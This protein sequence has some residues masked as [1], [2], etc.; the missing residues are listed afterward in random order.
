MNKKITIII[1][2]GTIL[3]TLSCMAIV[4]FLQQDDNNFHKSAPPPPP[5]RVGGEQGE[6]ASFNDDRNAFFDQ[7]HKAAPGTNWRKIDA[8]TRFQLMQERA[9]KYRTDDIAM[10]TLAD[11]AVIGEWKEMGSYNTAGRIWAT[12]VD[13][14]ND[15]VYA[16]SDGGNLWKG[17][18]D[19]T[20]WAVINDNFKLTGAHTL[21]KI[22]DRL[23]VGSGQ[24]GVQG[25]FY[26]EDEGVTWNST[27]GLENV[28]AWGYVMDAEILN[29]AEHTM[30]VLAYEWDYTNWW[31]IVSLYRSVDLG[32]SFTKV[33]SYDVPVYGGTNHFVLWSPPYGSATCYMVENNHVNVLD[34]TG[35]PVLV[36]ELPITEDGDY[37]LCGFE[38][39]SATDLYVA[40]RSYV[41]NFT[42]F[43]RSSDGGANWTATGMVEEGNFSKNSFSCSQSLQGYLYYGGVDSYR[44]FTGGDTWVRNNYWWEYYGDTEYNLHADIPF[45]RSFID[46]SGDEIVLVSTDGGLFRS[47]DHGL[48]WNNITNEGMRNAQ[49]YDVYTYRYVPDI[50]FAG[51]QDQGYQRSTYNVDDKYY[52][53]QLI[54]GDYGHF[55]SMNGGDDLWCVYPGFAMFVGDA[56]SGSVMTTWDF[57]G[58][59]HLWMAP[60][61]QDPWNSQVAWWGGGSDAGGAYLWR[62]QKSGIY[63]SAVKQD[64]NFSVAGGGSISAINYS[65]IDPNYWYLL[66][67]GGKFYYSEDAG[68]TWSLSSGFTGP[69]P[70]YFYGATIEPSKSQLG[71]VYI[72]GSGYDNAP[73][74]VS[75]DHGDNFTE[76][77]FGL[78][79]TLVY[80]LA[81]DNTDSLLFAATEVAPYV[82]VL[83]EG[84]W[85]NLAGND[86]PL[87]TYWSVDYVDEIKSVR[88]GTYGRGAWEFALRQDPTINVN[89]QSNALAM[90][91]YPNPA[92]ERL[93]IMIPMNL[94]Q[95]TVSIVDI[96][97]KV[98]S[99]MQAALNKNVPFN[100]PVDQL[101]VGSYMIIVQQGERTFTSKFIRQ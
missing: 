2:I 69:G 81:V 41:D 85:Y 67:S 7:M 84:K 93:Q 73:V 38:G 74:Y 57:Q 40:H 1:V 72:G 34:A 20:N 89:D 78:P 11:G 92:T 48:I 22:G 68:E 70:Q 12:E 82:C 44:S 26:T 6:D 25:I 96:Q 5:A 100:I 16:F 46:P 75:T 21:R 47:D 31:D 61:M 54:S 13:F 17:D 36:G 95:A 42:H 18:L 94:P 63:I 98:I 99:K 55:V 15:V 62:L 33:T 9:I 32:V 8:D 3:L 23:I 56:A 76:L 29:D 59:G 51:A 37:M 87:Q 58:Y 24:W 19:G 80:D 39:P 45:I 43:Y 64:K 88:F 71:V 10:D 4:F 97:G 52:F 90:Q 91:V 77:N 79:P 49:Y 53:D 101:P 65:P 14:E 27:S 30:Y 66:T 83:S 50:I 28:A 35:M 60:I 86:A